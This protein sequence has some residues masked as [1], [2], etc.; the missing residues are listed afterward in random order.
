MFVVETPSTSGFDSTCYGGN[1]GCAARASS[2]VRSLTLTSVCGEDAHFLCCGLFWIGQ[3][4]GYQLLLEKKDKVCESL[5]I[6]G[7]LS[8][9][10]NCLS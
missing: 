3:F 4:F 9:W 6:V 5:G 8:P 1:L 7:Q 10:W 2:V